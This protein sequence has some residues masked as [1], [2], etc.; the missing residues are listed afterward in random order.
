MFPPP[1]RQVKVDDHHIQKVSFPSI[2]LNTK[3]KQSHKYN[4]AFFRDIFSPNS[5]YK[6]ML[7]NIYTAQ[8]FLP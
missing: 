8:A 3:T 5:E 4:P 2:G 7:T 6:E 1:R